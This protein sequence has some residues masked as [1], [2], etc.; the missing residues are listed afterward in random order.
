LNFALTGLN[1]RYD[2]KLL[3]ADNDSDPIEEANRQYPGVTR[4]L[5]IAF[6]ATRTDDGMNVRIDFDKN[7]VDRDEIT[8]LGSL[9]VLVLKR[10]AS[11]KEYRLEEVVLDNTEKVMLE[12]AITIEELAGS[13]SF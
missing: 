9:L 4:D 10:V 5:K 1:A 6:E 2:F 7:S 11:N 13:F 3:R 12:K 8:N